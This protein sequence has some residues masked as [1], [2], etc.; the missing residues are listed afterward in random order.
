MPI[1]LTIWGWI[2]LTA[3]FAMAAY[4]FYTQDQITQSDIETPHVSP[5]ASARAEQK[6]LMM[7]DIDPSIPHNPKVVVNQN[8]SI[9]KKVGI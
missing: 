4:I 8:W 1:Y 6:G 2:A 5:T 7:D 3:H 9:L